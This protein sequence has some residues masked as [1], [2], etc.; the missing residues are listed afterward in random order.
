V[1]LFWEKPNEAMEESVSPKKDQ[2]EIPHTYPHAKNQYVAVI[3]ALHALPTDI[4]PL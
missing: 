3:S 4:V 1:F 2:V